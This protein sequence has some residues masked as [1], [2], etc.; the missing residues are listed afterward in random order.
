MG[1]S[2][3]SL[4]VFMLLK[5]SSPMEE[6]LNGLKLNADPDEERDGDGRDFWFIW[7]PKAL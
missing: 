5:G 1:E 7:Q 3:V 6:F 4:R 2:N